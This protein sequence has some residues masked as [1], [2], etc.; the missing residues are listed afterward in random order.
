MTKQLYEM[1]YIVAKNGRGGLGS[2]G[3]KVCVFGR[4][5]GELVQDQGPGEERTESTQLGTRWQGA[6]CGLQVCRCRRRPASG[7]GKQTPT[8]QL[9]GCPADQEGVR[10]EHAVLH[11][12][13]GRPRSQVTTEIRR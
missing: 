11:N 8:E 12:Q 3:R 5:R 6:G 1:R 13:Q 10:V 2:V 9:I 4:R 7:T